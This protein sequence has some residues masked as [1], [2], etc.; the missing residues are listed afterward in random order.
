MSKEHLA[1]GSMLCRQRFKG[2]ENFLRRIAFNLGNTP[3]Q[4]EVKIIS[5]IPIDVTDLQQKILHL[6]K[7]L[8]GGHSPVASDSLKD[9]KNLKFN[10]QSSSRRTTVN[11]AIV[12][13]KFPE[14]STAA[15]SCKSLDCDRSTS[16]TCL[17]KRGKSNV[18][19]IFPNI[20]PNAISD[21][22]FSCGNSELS[23]GAED[24]IKA[25]YQSYEAAHTMT[26]QKPSCHRKTFFK[27]KKKT[28][29][30]KKGTS[31]FVYYAQTNNSSPFTK[32]E[33]TED[34]KCESDVMSRSYLAQ[35]INKQYKPKVIG[36]NLSILSQFSSPV[37]RDVQ[38]RVEGACRCESDI[39]SC[40]YGPF[41]NIDNHMNRLI[42]P[43]TYMLNE[44]NLGNMYYDTKQ[45]DMI[46]V[47]EKPVK[48]N[49]ETARK[50]EHKPYFDIKCWPESI[51]SKYHHS[52]YPI[53]A[54]YVYMPP[55]DC[56][57][58][59]RY[60]SH[61][62][63]IP[64]KMNRIE[65]IVRKVVKRRKE[66]YKRERP[67]SIETTKSCS[68]DFGN[69][70]SKK[71]CKKPK[72]QEI[73]QTLLPSKKKQE[74][75]QTLLP[76]KKNAECLT[77]NIETKNCNTIECQTATNIPAINRADAKTEQTL[78][79]I[80]V[81]LQS[82]LAEVKVTT[83]MKNQVIRD[84]PKKDAVVQKGQSHNNMQ[85]SSLMNS[86]NYSPYSTMN[87]SAYMATCSPQLN[88]SQL[89]GV[90]PNQLYYSHEGMKCFHNF[91][92][93]IQPPGGRPM[94][95]SC[96][97]NSSHIKSS[98][99]KHAAT[100]ATNTEEVQEERTKETEKLIKEIYKSM[101]LT[102]DLP[103]KDSSLSEYDE[104]LKPL[105]LK[106]EPKKQPKKI[107]NVVQA[108]SELFIKKD[109]IDTSD[110]LN[111]TVESKVLSNEVTTQSQMVTTTDTSDRIQDESYNN[112]IRINHTQPTDPELQRKV[113]RETLVQ[114]SDT[115]ETETSSTDYDMESTTPVNDLE[116]KQKKEKQGL[117]S[118]M[119]KSVKLFKV[120]EKPKQMSVRSE[121]EE[122]STS[123][124]DDYQTVYSQK[125][126]KSVKNPYRPH[127]LPKRKTHSKISYKQLYQRDR[128]PEKKRSP[129]MEQEYRRYWDERLMFQNNRAR[130]SSER[131]Y[132]DLTNG[133]HAR[134]QTY[135]ARSALMEPKTM[136]P[137][138]GRQTNRVVNSE[139][140]LKGSSK[141]KPW[142]RIHKPGIHCGCGEA[143]KKKLLEG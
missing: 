36:D 82:V 4:T 24:V 85:G 70:Y 59:D 81:I 2:V 102:M 27:K 3:S 88:P 104:I 138:T 94:C 121:S 103:N 98:Y 134:Y 50:K 37:C 87:P 5:C 130:R 90:M 14:V 107:R 6:E 96:Y 105:I 20:D 57:F 26:E 31:P 29:K 18:S 101:A 78:N 23:Q 111:T 65:P 99:M 117:F 77:T 1:G 129:Y 63:K 124:S 136:S 44:I 19:F 80:K 68:V 46:P 137:K 120:K 66:I 49:T 79:Q 110:T 72:K 100:I 109:M 43:Q 86:F 35:M 76:S 93:F 34:P 112:Y 51:R 125:I 42:H 92:L 95:T 132:S 83:Q 126:E 108:V 71:N 12:D 32:S 52:M 30:Y 33:Q 133:Y 123:D 53:P 9:S 141:G 97:R 7:Q 116:P 64:S 139:N 74:I 41:H 143:W 40:C 75:R 122:E 15:V 73:R 119:L 142:L 11:A 58:R 115:V 10:K 25:N 21:Q 84:K 131:M 89:A 135:E 17:Q 67:L 69:I 54:S 127:N 128:S 28:I 45:Y 114:H 106:S 38:P 140:K 118:K 113:V 48:L 55:A 13:S 47:K 56:V 39:C 91:P 22:P 16:P 60:D 62:K 61:G 8:D